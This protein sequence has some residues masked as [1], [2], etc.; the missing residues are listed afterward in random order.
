MS[1]EPVD[2]SNP[3]L[4][5][6]TIET[7]IENDPSIGYT[8]VLKQHLLRPGW[9]DYQEETFIGDIIGRRILSIR[10]GKIEDVQ[11][12]RRRDVIE[13]AL[14]QETGHDIEL[15]F[16]LITPGNKQHVILNAGFDKTGRILPIIA[17]ALPRHPFSE[18]TQD[19]IRDTN[20]PSLNLGGED[21]DPENPP[22]VIQFT[23]FGDREFKSHSLHSGQEP[24]SVL[25]NT[26][27]RLLERQFRLEKSRSGILELRQRPLTPPFYDC[28]VTFPLAISIKA[29][30][31]QLR[32]TGKEWRNFFDQNKM[33]VE[34]SQKK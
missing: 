10:D 28:I 16:A 4:S 32:G 14:G 24:S 29:I 13:I 18:Q 26:D 6:N 1:S 19:Q 15:T 2:H 11:L 20:P 22:N 17:Q 12:R 25:Y 23:D 30:N 3:F 9:P 27:F 34:F 21:I 31:K 7:V 5:E 8:K 33:N